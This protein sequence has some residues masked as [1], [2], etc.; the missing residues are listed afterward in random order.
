M[1]K[2]RRK[3]I[4]CCLEKLQASL[5]LLKDTL[6]A[7]REA[8]KG[9]LDNE[10]N[11]EKIEATEELIERLEDALSSLEEAVTTLENTNF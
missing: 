11:Q 8:Y 10:E 2:A 1:N 4:D 9:I 7:E 6:A 3:T 5:P